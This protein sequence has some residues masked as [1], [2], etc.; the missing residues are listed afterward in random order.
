M[1]YYYQKEENKM[2]IYIYN[3]IIKENH[4]VKS[5]LANKECPLCEG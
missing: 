1:Y 4:L 2:Y 3:Y 5:C